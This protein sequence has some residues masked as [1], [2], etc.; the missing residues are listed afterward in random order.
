MTLCG[1]RSQGLPAASLG[2]S[3]REQVHI[4]SILQRAAEAQGFPSGPTVPER[5]PPMVFWGSPLRRLETRCGLH[6]LLLSRCPFVPVS[7]TVL[8]EEGHCLPRMQEED[9]G[10]IPGQEVW[11][12]WQVPR[13][14]GEMGSEGP[15]ML[16]LG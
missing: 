11:S 16:S 3:P 10:S 12:H 5:L 1:G 6:P 9:A 2:T 8:S 4:Y 7:P 15:S 13:R 14:V